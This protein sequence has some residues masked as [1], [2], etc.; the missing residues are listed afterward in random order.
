M[1]SSKC[2]YL[3]A[4]LTLVGVAGKVSA[5][6]PAQLGLGINSSLTITGE[7]GSVY[8]IQYTSNPGQPNSWHCK[9][10]LRLPTGSQSIAG[11]APMAGSPRFYQA[12]GMR[13]QNMVFIPAGN[14]T[15]G[16]PANEEDRFSDEGPQTPVTISQGFWIG[17]R[18]VTQLE[19]NSIMGTNP[20]SFAGTL[21]LPVES[22]SWFDATNY[23]ARLTEQ[24]VAGH[25]IPAGC[26]YRLPTEAEWEYACRAETT[27]R[28]NYG[29]D[30]GYLNFSTYAWYA[31][32]SSN[33]THPVAT[34]LPNPWGIYDMYGNVW[35]WCQDWYGPY[36]GVPVTD[37]KGPATGLNRVLRAG[38][39]ADYPNL[40]RTACRILDEPSA[41]YSTYGLRVVLAPNP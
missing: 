17:A 31:E 30:P 27:T 26:Q 25:R 15:L 24:A 16:S 38:S 32:N 9:T 35:Q 7:V 41:L 34:K 14:F 5:Q 37:P 13:P 29:D 11:T 36:P 10:L 8:A 3:L 39:W 1:E 21:E 6:A 28:F 22:V 19:Y 18:P 2:V 40:C 23:C 33:Q 4:L 12:V 20:S